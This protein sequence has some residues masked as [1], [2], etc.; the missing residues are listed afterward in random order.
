MS[1]SKAPSP[2]RQQGAAILEG[3]L[4]TTMLVLLG[5]AVFEV[6][7][8]HVARHA[9]MLALVQAGR[10]LSVHHGNLSA[11]QD[12]FKQALT[13]LFTPPGSHQSPENRR[14]T[15]MARHLDRFGVPLWQLEVA[16]PVAATFVDFA[17]AALSRKYGRLTINNDYLPEQHQRHVE[18]GWLKGMG[19]RSGLDVFAAN[20]AQ[21]N[22][23][24][25]YEP[26]TPG[27]R[28]ILRSLSKRRTTVIDLP[29]LGLGLGLL[30][31]VLTHPVVMQSHPMQWDR[32]ASGTDQRT[33]AVQSPDTGVKVRP[34]ASP[35]SEVEPAVNPLMWGSAAAPT[36]RRDPELASQ[37]SKDEPQPVAAAR[38]LC[39]VLLC[40]LSE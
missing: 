16:Q 19:P 21:L 18:R 38:A 34:G 5:F 26:H 4:F 8:W 37:V 40:C 22:L 28:A 10:A 13:P 17:D 3:C 25:L 7:R 6:A 27:V 24:Y 33:V 29:T 30:P 32:K 12:A 1:V 31:I 9:L 11:A 20:T 15:M 35:E 36:Q 14:D 23:T 39:G 2:Y